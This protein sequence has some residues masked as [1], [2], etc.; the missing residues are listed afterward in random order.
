MTKVIIRL[1]GAGGELDSISIP[2]DDATGD[3][4]RLAVE[5]LAI[6]C[7]IAVGDTITVT[8]E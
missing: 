2:E 3:A 7:V 4:I 6:R 5:T 1:N 8:E